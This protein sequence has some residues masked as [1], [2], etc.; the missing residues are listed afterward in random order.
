MTRL[1]RRQLLIGGA[2]LAIVGSAGTL[3][4]ALRSHDTSD[5][6]EAVVRARLPNVRL[7]PPS[8]REFATRLANAA[9]FRSQK[10]ALALDLDALAPSVVRIAPEVSR[11]IE[12][13]ERHVLSTYL[14]SSN[15]FRVA[16][17]R[18][19]TILC[20]EPLLACGNPF[21]QFRHE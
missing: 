19:E 12:G 3:W 21:A 10:I 1:D 5:W 11:R 13:L 15:F 6:I 2:A 8:L 16:D 4:L 7:D 17:P 20:S 14:L 9:E 18:A